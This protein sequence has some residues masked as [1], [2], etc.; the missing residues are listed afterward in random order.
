MAKH[1]FKTGHR[2]EC[3]QWCGRPMMVMTDP[4]FED[5]SVHD[6]LRERIARFASENG[7]TWKAKLRQL[8]TSGK[9]EG[10]LRQ[11]RNIIGPSGI[12]RITSR[13]LDRAAQAVK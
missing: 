9:D 5:C 3:C 1:L 6:E 12:D 10:L 2:Q 4:S 7:R 11:A 8:W 13:V